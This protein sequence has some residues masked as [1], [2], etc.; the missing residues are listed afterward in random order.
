MEQPPL[1]KDFAYYMKIGLSVV[2]AKFHGLKASRDVAKK[3][4]SWR[5]ST[6]PFL[7]QG[8]G[9]LNVEIDKLK[10]NQQRFDF[11][12]MGKHKCFTRNWLLRKLLWGLL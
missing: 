6:R 8:F 3:K 7:D 2:C 10:K 4:T 1:E 5:P 9:T 11:R 12:V